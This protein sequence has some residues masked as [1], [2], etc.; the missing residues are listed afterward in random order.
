MK[1]MARVVV[2]TSGWHYDSWRGPFFPAGLP[3]KNQLQFY[4]LTSIV[5]LIT[6]H[7]V[8]LI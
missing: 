5:G 7:F 8:F 4:A 2:G 1:A 6:P 3:L